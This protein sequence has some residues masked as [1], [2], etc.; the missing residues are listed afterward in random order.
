[1]AKQT[2]HPPK[3]TAR[4]AGSSESEYSHIEYRSTHGR[5]DQDTGSDF[6]ITSVNVPD[7]LDTQE[8]RARADDDSQSSVHRFHRDD[9]FRAVKWLAGVLLLVAASV[10]AARQLAPVRA[11]ISPAGIEAQV[12][13]ALG[14]PVSVA[15]TELRFSP[16]PR[17]IITGMVAQSGWRLPE[18]AVDFNWRDVLRGLQTSSWALGEARVAAIELTGAEALALLQSV[19]GASGLSAAV[20][21]IRLQ[22]VSFP[23]LVFLSGRYEAVIRRDGKKDF[24]SVSLKRLDTDGQVDLEIT[25]PSVPDGSA[26]FAL[27]ATK[28]A[29]AVGPAVTW[30]EANAQ[31]EFRADLLKVDSY[32]V[33]AQFG[34]LNGA[35]LIAREGLGWRLTGN[36]RGP[37]LNLEELIRHA[38]GLGG[39]EAE[40]A[41]I[42]LRGIAKFDLPLSGTGTTV[43]QMLERAK[44]AGTVSVSGATLGGLN[45]GLAATQG[46]ASAAGGTTRFADLEF[47]VSASGDGLVVRNVAGRAG[48]LRVHGGFDVDRK[49][50]LNGS[51][52]PEVTSPRGVVGTQVRLGG[53]IAAPTYR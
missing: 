36:V 13:K 39:S 24:S 37:D 25:P 2:G 19:R 31:G 18:I 45:L 44:A 40:L 1:M 51:L 6:A 16:T 4:K 34:N 43:N 38:A 49:L 28:W 20:S 35:A 47:D 15:D 29:A 26:K 46:G 5:W 42:P 11:A 48:N 3:E 52:R 14:V 21:T 30:S 23:D 41:R 32:S 7:R 10:W 33:G 27:F 12:S 22:R 50:Q 8:V 17:L 53:T 9:V